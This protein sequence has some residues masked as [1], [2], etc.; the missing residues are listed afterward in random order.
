MKQTQI[1]APPMS[2]MVA[3]GEQFSRQ[4]VLYS[5]A[6]GPKFSLI[7][8]A[9]H[10]SLQVALFNILMSVAGT[11]MLCMLDVKIE[12]QAKLESDSVVNQDGSIK[13]V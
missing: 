11:R 6:K 8:D 4:M 9:Q 13:K 1:W 7:G 2:Y 10:T 3:V 12:H 5:G